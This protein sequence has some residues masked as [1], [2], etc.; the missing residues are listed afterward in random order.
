VKA[1]VADQRIAQAQVDNADGTRVSLGSVDEAI[2]D[3]ERE[4]DLA[5]RIHGHV[6]GDTRQRLRATRDQLRASVAIE[7]PPADAAQRLRLL[8][9]TGE[10]LHL[11][12]ERETAARMQALVRIQEGLAR[13]RHCDTPQDLIDAA[14]S[15]LLRTCGFTRAMVSRVRG[16]LWDPEVLEVEP[17]IDPG[18]EAFQDYVRSVEIP[19][20]HM[21]METE[22]VRRRIPVLVED[23]YKDPRTFKPLVEVSRC[24]SYAAAPIMP[25]T[26][27]IGFF[28]VDRFGQDLPVSPVDRDNLWIFAEHFGLLYERAVLLERLEAQRR[29]LHEILDDAE[30]MVDEV[31]DAE[32]RLVRN[33]SA[34]PVP[35]SAPGEPRS[36]VNKLLSAREQEVLDL[37][38]SGATN[39]QIARELVLSEGTVKSHVKRILRKLRVDSRAA[40]VARYL[41]LVSLE[42]R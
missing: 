21:L 36:A 35:T 12:E 15:E 5:D 41:R 7:S 30:A 26:R 13:L 27:V 17:Y 28:H 19:L 9:Q 10:E 29:R 8:A 16:S 2:R 39:N 31:C 23:P 20:E 6:R 24:T 33:E 14:P 4:Q 11:I 32:I 38:A 25:T 40:A 3:A 42:R 37:M 34:D 1:T 18:E 22:M